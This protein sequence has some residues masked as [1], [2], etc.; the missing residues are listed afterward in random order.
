MWIEPSRCSV[1]YLFDVFELTG[2]LNY[3]LRVGFIHMRFRN[4]G[5]SNYFAMKVMLIFST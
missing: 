1:N 3:Y 4:N 2:T 5:L